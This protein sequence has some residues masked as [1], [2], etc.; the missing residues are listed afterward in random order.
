MKNN[1]DAGNISTKIT[2]IIASQADHLNRSWSFRKLTHQQSISKTERDRIFNELITN[3]I[4]L[5][6]LIAGSFKKTFIKDQTK[7][8]FFAQ[9]QLYLM[10]E[11][12]NWLKELG[13]SEKFTELWKQVINQRLEEY[14]KDASDYKKELGNDIPGAQWLAIVPTGCLH[15]IRRG[16]TDIEDP[17]FKV[18]INHHKNIFKSFYNLVH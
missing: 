8:Q 17:L 13:V 7:Y 18:I 16:K 6:I 15:H 10:N 2:K 9:L 14:R 1:L 11:Y 3:P 4:A 12:S 5:I